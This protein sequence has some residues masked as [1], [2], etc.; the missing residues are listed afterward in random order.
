V[1]QIDILQHFTF[2]DTCFSEHQQTPA[3]ELVPNLQDEVF[4]S[5]VP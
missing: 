3:V 1:V 2:F 4:V 5:R